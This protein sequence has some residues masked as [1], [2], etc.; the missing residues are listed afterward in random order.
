MRISVLVAVS[1]VSLLVAGCSTTGVP[2]GDGPTASSVRP[3]TTSSPSSVKPSAVPTGVPDKGA[4]MSSVIAWVEAGTAAD[5]GGFHTATRDGEAT[6]LG[7]DIAFVTAGA[8]N[9]MTDKNFEGAL[10][11]LIHPSAPL[12]QPPDT[13]GH[14][15][16]GWVDFA[17]TTAAVGSIH[18]DPGRFSTGTGPQLKDGQT[19]AFGDYRCRVGGGALICVNY[20]HQTGLRFSDAGVLPFGCLK[21]ITPPA[22]GFGQQFGC[23]DA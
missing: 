15:V 18:G 4:D 17:G 6:D 11:C 23:K 9:C 8:I 5:A 7:T 2:S 21:P 3:S 10:A 19:L 13:Y 22:A 1:A 14:W 16:P 20:A 12:P